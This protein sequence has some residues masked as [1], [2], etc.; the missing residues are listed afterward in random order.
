ML[1]RKR[2]A[3]LLASSLTLPASSCN[4]CASS[5]FPLCPRLA[6]TPPPSSLTGSDQL[7]VPPPRPRG[8]R[9]ADCVNGVRVDDLDL[10]GDGVNVDNLD[11]G[12]KGVVRV[13]D[14]DLGGDEVNV[15]N[16]D[17]GGDEVKVEI[18]SVVDEGGRRLLPNPLSVD[19]SLP[20][21]GGALVP[22]PPPT[23]SPPFHISMNVT[24]SPR[25]KITCPSKLLSVKNP[26]L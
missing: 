10:E 4:L 9:S 18:L 24:P 20:A 19:L 23:C 7:F 13:A 12:G 5:E 6:W 22:S 1:K 26:S 15:D 16:L 11:L 8:L 14:L 21:G 3:E 2:L 17:L 25:V